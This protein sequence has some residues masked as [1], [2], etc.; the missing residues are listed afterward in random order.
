MIATGVL[1]YPISLDDGGSTDELELEL[2]SNKKN[3]KTAS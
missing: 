2:E 3:K 1:D